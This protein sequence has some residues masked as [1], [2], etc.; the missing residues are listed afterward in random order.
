MTKLGTLLF[1]CAASFFCFSAT[2]YADDFV[3][4][5]RTQEEYESGHVENSINIPFNEIV[6]GVTANDIKTEDTI[7]VYCLSGKRAGRAKNALNN[8]GYANVVSLG[9]YE[10]AMVYFKEHPLK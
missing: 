8:A 3:V 10:D 2:G 9:G 1:A 5:V 6:E 7:Y 4:D